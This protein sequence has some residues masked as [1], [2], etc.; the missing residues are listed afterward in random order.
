MQN[1]PNK[2]LYVICLYY[3][4]GHPT[5]YDLNVFVLPSINNHMPCNDVQYTKVKAYPRSLIHNFNVYWNAD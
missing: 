2:T 4:Y 3:L 5:F 1:K